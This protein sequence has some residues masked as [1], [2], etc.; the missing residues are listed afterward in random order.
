MP[1]TPSYPGIYIEEI[2]SSSHTIS[3]APTSITVFVGYTHP[4]KTNPAYWNKAVRIFS[5]TDYQR[6]FGGFFRSTIFTSENTSFGDMASAVSQFFLNGGADAY[7]VAV[8][9][10]PSVPASLPGPP[11]SAASI[12]VGGASASGIA[13]IVFT[14]L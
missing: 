5:F 14:A 8:Q 12:T 13:G 11:A 7:I 1:V 4:L 9:A 10:A 6:K 3:A 2:P